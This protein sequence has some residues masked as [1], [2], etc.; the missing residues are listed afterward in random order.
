MGERIICPRQAEG[1]MEFQRQFKPEWETNNWTWQRWFMERVIRTNWSRFRDW[2][3]MRFGIPHRGG[4]SGGT[5]WP[6]GFA[7]PRTCSYCGGVHPDDA[8]AL[9]KA[10]WEVDTTTKSYKRYLEPPG[11]AEFT[12]RL[13]ENI[14][15]GMN[16]RIPHIESPVPPVTLYVY[17][18]SPKQIEAFN[19][20]LLSQRMKKGLTDG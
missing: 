4:Y 13:V 10:G 5:Y 17:H 16:E 7:K 8:L 9:L 2:L 18:F 20:E 19:A 3:E 6:W 11:Y 1:T 15:M 14:H 12:K